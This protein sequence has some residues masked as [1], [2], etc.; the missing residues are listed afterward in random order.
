MPMESFAYHHMKIL[1]VEFFNSPVPL[2]A[3]VE[4]IFSFVIKTLFVQRE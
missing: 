3:G 4:S 1:L 2:S